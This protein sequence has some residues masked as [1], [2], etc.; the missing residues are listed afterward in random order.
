[1]ATHSDLQT[2]KKQYRLF[3]HLKG[4]SHKILSYVFWYQSIYLKFLCP[5]G[6]CS[7]AF[8][9]SFSCRII[10]FSCLGVVSLSCESSWAIK[11][12]R[13]FFCSPVLGH[14]RPVL[15][16]YYYAERRQ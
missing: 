3:L 14:S 10:L 8:K 2:G 12:F 16:I 5:S 15:G 1:M 11:T 13:S 6:A 9:I 4:W 7:F